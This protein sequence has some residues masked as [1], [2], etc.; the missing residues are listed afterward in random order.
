MKRIAKSSVFGRM[1]RLPSEP[2][3]FRRQI[4][5][6]HI[7]RKHTERAEIPREKRQSNN[8]AHQGSPGNSSITI[9]IVT[10]IPIVIVAI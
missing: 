4:L 10:I 1:Q 9:K 7:E 3:C 2:F 8:Y 5:E 6:K